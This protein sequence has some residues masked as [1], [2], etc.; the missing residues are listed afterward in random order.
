VYNLNSS[1]NCA[2]YSLIYCDQEA[3][4][5]E[6]V[7]KNIAT[8]LEIER[9]SVAV[10]NLSAFARLVNSVGVGLDAPVQT[11]TELSREDKTINIHTVDDTLLT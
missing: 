9:T 7:S 11:D 3:I 6:E 8:W 4:D 5:G 2:V 1:S 10:D